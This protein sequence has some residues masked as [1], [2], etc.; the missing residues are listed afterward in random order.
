MNKKIVHGKW[1][2]FCILKVYLICQK[3]TFFITFDKVLL[4]K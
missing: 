1:T 2:I 4:A 3:P